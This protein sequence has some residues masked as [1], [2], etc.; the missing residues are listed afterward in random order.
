MPENKRVRPTRSVLPAR[1]PLLTPHPPVAPL[2]P[3]AHVVDLMTAEGSA[4]FGA[5]GG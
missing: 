3:P 2:L 1:P 5:S 4:A